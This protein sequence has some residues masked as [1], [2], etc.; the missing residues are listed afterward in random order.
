[1]RRPSALT[2]FSISALAW[3][4]AL[5]LVWTKVS[6]WTSYPVSVL[7]HLALE[8][9]APMWVRNVQ[10]SPGQMQVQT[11]VAMPVLDAGGR[12][13]EIDVELDPGR[14]AY[15]LPIFLALLLAARG[16]KRLSKS[17]AGYLLLLP[18]QAFSATMYVLMQVVLYAQGS[19]GVLRVDH[20][21]VESIV[22]GYQ[23]GSLVVPTLTPIILWLWLDRKFFSEV[24]VRGWQDET[25]KGVSP[26]AL[27]QTDDV[28]PAI[29]RVSPP[30]EAQGAV[31]PLVQPGASARRA[32]AISSSASVGLPKRE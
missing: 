3:L 2:V 17:L 12:L 23:L 26:P 16:Q 7:T 30:I 21:Q 19:A 29:A 8:Q 31:P 32:P 1:M 6:P 11:T 13:G 18:A 4:I 10:K 5:T 28:S 22:Y 14:Y 9:G 15:G 27:Q 24:I 25:P 20:W